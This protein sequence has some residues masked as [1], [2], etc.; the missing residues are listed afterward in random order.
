MKTKI[1]K[2]LCISLCLCFAFNLSSC[3]K[4]I[5]SAK[6]AIWEND[7]MYISFITSEG[8][9]KGTLT[10]DGTT[11]NIKLSGHRFLIGVND[12]DF[13]YKYDEQGNI[14]LDRDENGQTINANL[15]GGLGYIKKDKLYIEIQNDNLYRTGRSKVDYTG[16]TIVLY[17]KN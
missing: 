16:K 7:F 9:P 14:I 15:W 6:N 11:Y 5:I 12:A 17:R 8:A 1:F 2:L 4:E 13:V 10:I 3:R